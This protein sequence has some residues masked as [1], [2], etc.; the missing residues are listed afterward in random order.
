V[1][2]Y[3][4]KFKPGEAVTLPAVATAAITGGQLV[5]V[6]G[7]PAAADSVT[8]VGVAAQDVAIGQPVGVYTDGVQRLTAAGAFAAGT[9]L[10]CA[11]NGQVTTWVSGT[12]N[13]DRYVGL[14]LEAASGAASVVAVRMAR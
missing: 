6:A 11:A 1:A 12:D 10:K 5:T 9:P 2:D 3:L 13:Y 8:W 7:A 4:P 14:A